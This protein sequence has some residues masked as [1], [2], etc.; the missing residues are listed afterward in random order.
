MPI[1]EI[2]AGITSLCPLVEPANLRMFPVLWIFFVQ[3]KV[4]GLMVC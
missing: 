2:D 3:T 1:E 4:N